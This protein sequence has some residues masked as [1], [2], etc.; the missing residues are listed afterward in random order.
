MNWLA[1]AIN[2]M[3]I[4][5][6]E[7]FVKK[8][9]FTT[10]SSLNCSAVP[11]HLDDDGDAKST[12]SE[13]DWTGNKRFRQPDVSSSEDDALETD[14]ENEDGDLDDIVAKD[15]HR[16]KRE[17]IDA[18]EDEF[19]KFIPDPV[20]ENFVFDENAYYVY[21]ASIDGEQVWVSDNED[22]D[23]AA[24][25]VEEEAHLDAG[26][27]LRSARKVIED[28]PTTAEEDDVAADDAEKEA[29]P[30]ARVKL[31][32]ARKVIVDGPPTDEDV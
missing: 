17:R 23:D 22:Y 8:T 20:D 25:D 30:D 14:N 29:L 28:D 3:S 24:D 10:T 1:C 26:V 9:F 5:T 4:I 15:S 21:P 31:R 12:I 19:F 16:K 11:D 18:T 7:W 2:L 6:N 13:E 32:S 27:K